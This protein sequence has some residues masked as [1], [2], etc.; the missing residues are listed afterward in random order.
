MS[1]GALEP[2]W[3]GPP[4]RRCYAV[5]H[6]AGGSTGVLMASPLLHEQP[7]S[8]RALVDVAA[9][10]AALGLP[11]LHF[12]WYG[13]GDSAGAGECHDVAAMHEDLDAAMSALR[14]RGVARVVLLA[15]GAASLVV[16]S[17][18]GRAALP[19]WAAWEPVTDG[20][21]WLAALLA[22]DGAE[23]QLRYGGQQPA[24]GDMNLMGV[25]V[26]AAWRAGIGASRLAMA[27]PPA[28][29]IVARPGEVPEGAPRHF[30]L[31]ADA[32]RL[33][34]GVGV[35]TTLFLPRTVFAVVDELGRAFAAA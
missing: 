12:D 32:P 2:F 25:P 6:G 20:A 10:L 22:A 17:W 11:T 14:E 16:S 23:R 31:P 18:P 29:W 33:D 21:A 8:R 7:S 4:T 13:T 27:P 3:M 34:R 15:W 9:R 35:E 1:P 5:L 30:A 28:P 19:A 24:E 26:S